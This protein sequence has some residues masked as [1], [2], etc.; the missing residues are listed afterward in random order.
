MAQNR[1]GNLPQEH[2]ITE[3]ADRYGTV[4]CRV[5]SSGY[6][7][8]DGYGQKHQ[9]HTTSNITLSDGS[10]WN[11]LMMKNPGIFIGV[12]ES[13]RNPKFSIWRNERPTHGLT[14]LHTATR[15]ADSH[16]HILCCPRHSILC[17]D[18][19][20]RCPDCAKSYNGFSWLKKLFFKTEEQ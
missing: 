1:A 17:S 15:C 19:C 8:T 14:A 10:A 20:Y 2:W 12:C 7:V 9:F 5:G 16:C 3:V 11:P 6:I 4:I 13:C 18:G